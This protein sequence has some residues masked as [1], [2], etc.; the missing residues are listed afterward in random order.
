MQLVG[1]APRL[2]LRVGE[3]VGAILTG[4]GGGRLLTAEIDRRVL[5]K[6]NAAL[7]TTKQ[8]L[9]D[10]LGRMAGVSPEE[11]SSHE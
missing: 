1:D 9:A 6:D 4:V 11:K 2:A 7:T 3:L 5:Q 8:I 10:T